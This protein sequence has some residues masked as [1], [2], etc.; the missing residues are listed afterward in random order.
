MS[1]EPFTQLPPATPIKQMWTPKYWA[2]KVSDLKD[3]STFIKEMQEV[4]CEIVTSV[5]SMS[6]MLSLYGS[7]KEK[8]NK[9]PSE[10]KNQL[11]KKQSKK[12]TKQ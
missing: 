6:Q 11:K 4:V 3:S 10:K 5:Q 7:S 12:S 1:Q 8:K 9:T 2:E